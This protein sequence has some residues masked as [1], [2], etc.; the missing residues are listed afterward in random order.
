LGAVIFVVLVWLFLLT[1]VVIH[2]GSFVLCRL[3]A[4]RAGCWIRR[5][6][7]TPA[8]LELKDLTEMVADWKRRNGPKKT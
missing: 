7:S 6:V 4:H 3:G 2:R 1:M 5:V 8:L